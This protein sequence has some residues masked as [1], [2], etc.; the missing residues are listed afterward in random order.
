MTSPIQPAPGTV[1]VLPAAELRAHGF[2]M[3]TD[4]LCEP[5]GSAG[6][7]DLEGHGLPWGSWG[8]A[9]HPLT[10]AEAGC[11]TEGVADTGAGT[12]ILGYT[13]LYRG[14]KWLTA[15]REQCATPRG[16][17]D[18]S[19][20][21]AALRRLLDE[22]RPYRAVVEGL[23]GVVLVVD[24]GGPEIR[25]D[26]AVLFPLAQIKRW[27]GHPDVAAA[28]L[29]AVF[30]EDPAHPDPEAEATPVPGRSGVSGLDPG[31]VHRRLHRG[32]AEMLAALA[33]THFRATGTALP[34]D[35]P[36]V[37]RAVAALGDARSPLLDLVP[38]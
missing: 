5:T 32:C 28:L 4:A 36:A 31:S 37:A 3:L 19:G 23:G 30:G 2:V 27:G 38:L 8:R 11:I 9:F 10:D 25:H 6:P 35:D 34:E 16:P 17:T 15:I 1:P 18:D 21:D 20:R 7:E 22:V 13:C 14:R 12:F 33:A 26:L 24:Y 29:A